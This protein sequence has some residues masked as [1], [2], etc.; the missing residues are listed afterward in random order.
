VYIFPSSALTLLLYSSSGSVVNLISPDASTSISPPIQTI[1]TE[2]DVQGRVQA[3]EL[4][5]LRAWD[6]TSPAIELI[7]ETGPSPVRRISN[8]KTGLKEHPSLFGKEMMSMGCDSPTAAL[9]LSSSSSSTSSSSSSSAA[10]AAAACPP[11][12]SPTSQALS[13]HHSVPNALR[14]KF[15]SF[16]P[17]AALFKAT[18]PLSPHDKFRI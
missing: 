5:V 4:A 13:A 7:S 17:Y 16:T 14:V 10:A 9:A 8:A 2:V 15:E 6:S 18:Q 11:S 12:P 1:V 3:L